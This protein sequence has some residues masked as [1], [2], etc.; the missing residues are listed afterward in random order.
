MDRLPNLLAMSFSYHL[1]QFSWKSLVPE[2]VSEPVTMLVNANIV[3]ITFCTRLQIA[4]LMTQMI[5][6]VLYS[7]YMTSIIISS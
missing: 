5:A 4:S 1:L 3:C 2:H 6:V 7:Y